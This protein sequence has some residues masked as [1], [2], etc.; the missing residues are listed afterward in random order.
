MRIALFGGSFDPVHNGHLHLAKT[1]RFMAALDEVI[2][3]PARVPP[4]KVGS[5][6]APPH[7][8][9]AMLKLAIEGLSG[10]IVSDMEIVS[11]SHCY[12]LDTVRRFKELRPSDV[13]FFIIGGDSLCDLHLWY[14]ASELVDEVEFLMLGRSGVHL[15]DMIAASPFSAQQK[16]RLGRGVLVAPELEISS[17][18]IRQKVASG[19]DISGFVPSNVQEYIRLHSLYSK[20]T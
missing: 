15:D 2:L 5:V 20:E 11:N 14:R 7:H 13:L 10:F 8:R 16:A 19:E 1:A 12:T 3:V 6:L 18:V 17:T 4:H 9:L